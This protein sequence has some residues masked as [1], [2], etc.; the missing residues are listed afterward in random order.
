LISTGSGH[1]AA[2]RNVKRHVACPSADPLYSA[3]MP[4]LREICT[5]CTAKTVP[6]RRPAA[7]VSSVF[8]NGTDTVN[9]TKSRASFPIGK[10]GQVPL[11]CLFLLFDHWLSHL[12]TGF[13]FSSTVLRTIW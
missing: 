13:A 9:W 2:T 7:A 8:S 1:L 11:M 12:F 3:C 4:F 6:K 5:H 10:S